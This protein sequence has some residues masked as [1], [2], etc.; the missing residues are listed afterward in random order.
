[1]KVLTWTLLLSAAWLVGCA[2]TG[3][4][5]LPIVVNSENVT[6]L[7]NR[8]WEL[9]SI[10][11]YG[12]QILMDFQANMTV[13]FGGDGK[14]AGSGSVNRFTGSYSFSRDGRLTWPGPSFTVTRKA[15]PPELM[16]KERDYL[17]ALP[18]TDRAILSGRLLRLESEDGSTA[19][20]FSEAGYPE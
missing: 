15:G 13:A 7:Y 3:K 20:T 18:K 19:L 1:M 8:Q 2:A 5:N 9:K 11:L 4:S 6:K 14:V 17:E 10:T 12:S 16:E